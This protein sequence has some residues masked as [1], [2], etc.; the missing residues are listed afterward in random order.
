MARTRIFKKDGA[1]TPYFWS[2][3]DGTAPDRKRIY[4]KTAEG[5]KRMK[6]AFFNARTNRVRKD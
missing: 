4:K 5:V 6:G 2:D 3:T 1:S